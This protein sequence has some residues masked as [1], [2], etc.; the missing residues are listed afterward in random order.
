MLNSLGQNGGN[1]TRLG[2]C[3]CTRLWTGPLCT[4]AKGKFYLK[5]KF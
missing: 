2:N 1:C 4:E 3:V 5:I